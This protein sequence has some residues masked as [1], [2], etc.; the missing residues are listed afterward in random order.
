MSTP[1]GQDPRR[2]PLLIL[3]MGY[4][5]GLVAGLTTSTLIVSAVSSR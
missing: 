5:L 3:V 2:L 4:G 1:P